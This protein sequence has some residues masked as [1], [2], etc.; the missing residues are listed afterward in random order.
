[1][2]GEKRRWGL[3]YLHLHGMFFVCCIEAAR[4]WVGLFLVG[5][6]YAMF[7]ALRMPATEFLCIV[8]YAMPAVWVC[9]AEASPGLAPAAVCAGSAALLTPRLHVAGVVSSCTVRA[10]SSMWLCA[11]RTGMLPLE[12]PA[13]R[14]Q[15]YT[16]LCG[17]Y[18]TGAA[19]CG[20]LITGT[21]SSSCLRSEVSAVVRCCL[22]VQ[23]LCAHSL[24]LCVCPS[25]DCLLQMYSLCVFLCVVRCAVSS[26]MKASPLQHSL[27]WR[28][29]GFISRD[30]LCM[31]CMHTCK[32][33]RWLMCW[34]WWGLHCLHG[35]LC[36]IV[37]SLL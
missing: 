25:Y 1:M 37:E 11:C 13:A 6:F 5:S 28:R 21:C 7:K 8:L 20:S 30:A 22:Q 27:C 4:W 2:V 16:A 3:G 14:V 35:A 31:H 10:L 32:A 23:R 26:S 24:Q 12:C 29:R 33:T 36:S 15:S 17:R 9:K 34:A 19:C 18:L